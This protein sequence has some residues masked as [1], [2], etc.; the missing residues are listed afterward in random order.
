[1][2]LLLACEYI[3]LVSVN[4]LLRLFFLPLVLC[5]DKYYSSSGKVN[6]VSLSLTAVETGSR[7]DTLSKGERFQFVI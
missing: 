5:I 2:K 7:L 1:M 4:N 3:N 6:V